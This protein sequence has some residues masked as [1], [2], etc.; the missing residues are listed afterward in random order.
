MLL[1]HPNGVIVVKW[2]GASSDSRLHMSPGGLQTASKGKEVNARG[3]YM[4]GLVQVCS[5]SSA[6]ALDLLQYCTEPLI[7]SSTIQLGI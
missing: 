7:C 3:H 6:N 1:H 5:N 4:E 2:E